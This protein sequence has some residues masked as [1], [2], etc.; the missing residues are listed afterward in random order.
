[1]PQRSFSVE[2]LAAARALRLQ[3]RGTQWNFHQQPTP[4]CKRKGQDYK[5]KWA[6]CNRY[7]GVLPRNLYAMYLLQL[8]LTPRQQIALLAP[9]HTKRVLKQCADEL[10]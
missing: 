7:H 4:Q 9:S 3:F 1:M 6:P 2:W 10:M 8:V 5:G